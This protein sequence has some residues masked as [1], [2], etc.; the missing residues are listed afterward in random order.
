MRPWSPTNCR[1]A[2]YR[3]DMAAGDSV[4]R[5][6]ALGPRPD[7]H[8]CPDSDCA[9][10]RRLLC[11]GMV[12]VMK[13]PPPKERPTKSERETGQTRSCCCMAIALSA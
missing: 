12:S 8:Y 6:R 9:I 13:G 3:I 2:P 4:E 11:R 10:H 1:G 5:T 7:V